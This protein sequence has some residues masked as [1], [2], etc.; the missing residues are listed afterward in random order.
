MTIDHRTF[1]NVRTCVHV[2][3]W[4]TNNTRRNIYAVADTRAARNDS[5]VLLNLCWSKRISVFIKKLETGSSGLIDQ[6]AHSEAEENSLLH[7]WVNLPGSRFSLLR[8][9]ELAAI[10]S[11]LELFKYCAII[12]S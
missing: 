6:F 5:N 3:R 10:Q 8:C 9:A 7:P 12:G 2:H 1:I 11:S 4:H